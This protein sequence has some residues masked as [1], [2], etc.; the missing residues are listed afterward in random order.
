[1]SGLTVHYN[2]YLVWLVR[3]LWSKYIQCICELVVD[4]IDSILNLEWVKF[5]MSDHVRSM[6]CLAW[7]LTGNPLK[8][9]NYHC[10]VLLVS[11][12][13]HLILFFLD[14]C[15]CQCGYWCSVASV[16]TLSYSSKSFWYAFR[17]HTCSSSSPSWT[18]VGVSIGTC[19]NLI[20]LLYSLWSSS[21]AFKHDTW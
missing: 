2:I 4:L 1:M 14:W 15:W 19:V 20:N 18:F 17:H 7:D 11:T 13:K 6:L 21:Y 12:C 8:M 5:G 3:R 10:C 9:V 16:P